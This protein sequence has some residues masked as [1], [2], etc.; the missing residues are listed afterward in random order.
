MKLFTKSKLALVAAGLGSILA[1]SSA[2]A[3][4]RVTAFGDAIAYKALISMDVESAK[5]EF[6]TKDLTKL[7]FVAANNLCV[8]QILSK[9]LSDAIATCNMALE[10]VETDFELS[11]GLEKEAKASIYSNLAVA[12]AMNGDLTGA[13]ADLERA[14]MLNIRDRNAKVNYNQISSTMDVSGD[15]AQN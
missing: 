13:S 8:T 10:K 7:D 11:A 2:S 4:Y 9:E 14:L 1:A 12:K 15:I 6:Y 3:E 5:S